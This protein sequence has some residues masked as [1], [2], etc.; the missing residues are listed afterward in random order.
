MFTPPAGSSAK[1]PAKAPGSRLEFG[2]PGCGLAPGGHAELGQDGRDMVVHGAG[3]HHQPLRDLR[4]RQAG[5][6]QP[7]DFQL[8][9]GK[10]GAINAIKTIKLRPSKKPLITTKCQPPGAK[11]PVA[12]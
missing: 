4:V 10:P 1:P 2:G 5:R 3:R 6:D 12:C 11:S 8:A 7:E 9:I